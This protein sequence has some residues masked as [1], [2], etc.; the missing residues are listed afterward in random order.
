MRDVVLQLANDWGEALRSYSRRYQQISTPVLI[1]V[2]AYDSPERL[3]DFKLTSVGIVRVFLFDE[4]PYIHLPGAGD[5]QMFA[6]V[7]DT[8]TARAILGR[9]SRSNGARTTK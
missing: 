9:G 8:F 7:R 4:K 1:L 5:V 6:T 3:R 2:G